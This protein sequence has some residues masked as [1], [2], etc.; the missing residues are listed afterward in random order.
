VGEFGRVFLS[1]LERCS[2]NS[3]L[4]MQVKERDNL[5]VIETELEIYYVA[6]FFDRFAFVDVKL[7]DP[8]VLKSSLRSRHDRIYF[9]WWRWV[10]GQN[11]PNIGRIV[12]MGELKWFESFWPKRQHV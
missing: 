3:Q 11:E 10:L 7:P 12:C 2:G 5:L 9:D 8:I 1:L 4:S 6:N